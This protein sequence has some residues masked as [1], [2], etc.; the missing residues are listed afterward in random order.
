MAAAETVVLFHSAYGPR[1]AVHEAAARLRAEGHEVL[2]PDLFDGRTTDDLDEG[3]A[4]RDELGT[5][6][7]LRRAVAFVAPHSAR[8]LVYAGFS[9][10]GAIAQ[11]L[12][13]GDEHARGLLLLHGTS[14][15]AD[16]AATDIA[17]QLHV[18]EPDPYETDDWLTAWYLRMGRAGADVEVH[19]YRGAGHLYTDPGLPDWDAEAADRTWAV[20]SAFLAEL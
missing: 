1:A 14:D 7:L 5:G 2:V 11:N 15:L 16:D 6:E 9:L 10:G 20:A 8:G 18:A 12:A 3:L 19:R 17:V 4:I 13:L